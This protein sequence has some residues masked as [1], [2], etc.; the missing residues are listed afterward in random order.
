MVKK[1]YIQP[2]LEVVS[3]ACQTSV[4]LAGSIVGNTLS[5]DIALGEDPDANLAP[6]LETLD[7][8]LLDLIDVPF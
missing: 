2:T 8:N 1:Q 5:D 7:L 6:E 4:L 3:I